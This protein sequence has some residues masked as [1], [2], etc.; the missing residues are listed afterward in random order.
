MYLISTVYKSTRLWGKRHCQVF[1]VST[2][3][4]ITDLTDQVAERFNLEMKKWSIIIHNWSGTWFMRI[5]SQLM[6]W[7]TEVIVKDVSVC[8][9]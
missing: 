2:W 8:N 1:Y 4:S 3:K 9:Q 7:D 5:S 6:R